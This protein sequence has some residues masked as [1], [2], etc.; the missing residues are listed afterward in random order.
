MFKTKLVLSI[1]KDDLTYE[2]IEIVFPEQTEY[3]IFV[4]SDNAPEKPVFKGFYPE[5]DKA[6][7]IVFE[8]TGIS[9]TEKKEYEVK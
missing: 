9:K 3:Q 7:N 5:Q 6:I 2:I 8:L 1:K 4:T